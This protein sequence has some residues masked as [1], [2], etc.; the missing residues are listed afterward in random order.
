MPRIESKRLTTLHHDRID[1]DAIG[2]ETL[3]AQ[4]F[5]PFASAAS[6]VE[7]WLVGLP[8][9]R[10]HQPVNVGRE[11]FD[12]IFTA[13]AENVFECRVER[14]VSLRQRRRGDVAPD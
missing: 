14:V 4:Q 2:R 12:D 3:P 13:A 10:H 11:T 8:G 9:P 6:D 7:D 1:I 5:Q